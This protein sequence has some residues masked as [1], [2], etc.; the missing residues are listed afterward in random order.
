MRRSRYLAF[1]APVA[2]VAAG[3]CAP[4]L[5]LREPVP[6]TPTRFEAQIS[7]PL[8][9]AALDRWWTVFDDSQLT[10]LVEQAL[11]NGADARLAL[12]RL[13]EARAIRQAALA[14]FRVQGDLQANA[15]AQRNETLSGDATVLGSGGTGGTPSTPGGA[16]PGLPA[17]G[18]FGGDTD[19]ASVNFNLSW[20]VDLFGRRGTTR[21]G[22]EADLAAARF[23]FEGSR[24]A[25]A[26]DVADALFAARGLAVQLDDARETERIQRDLRRVLALR[27]ERGLAP[28]ADVARIDADLGQ[29]E[30]A[31]AQLEAELT[32]A[33]RA[34]LVL[35]GASTAS[36]AELAITPSLATAPQPPATLPGELLQRR[37]DVREA[38]AR[39][40]SAVAGSELRRLEL[41]PRLTLNPGVGLTA[42]GGAFDY[43]IA[44][45]TLAAGLTQP[46][47]DRPRLLAE[48]RAQN[49]RAEQA[50]VTYERTVQVAFSEAD[51][52]LVRLAA[53]QRRVASLEAGARRA[54]VSYEAARTLFTRGLNDLQALLDAER[55]YRAARQALAAARVD[56]LRRAVT[57][58]RALGGG[59]P[60]NDPET[61][62]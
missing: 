48:L 22:A 60:A 40:R 20:E 32:A 21:R 46:I 58:Y 45:W 28:D 61:V 33:K 36:T 12:A 30:A 6:A 27:A 53:D 50:A 14:R 55:S 17:A 35:T 56:A 19:T 10:G 9:A 18:L 16:N 23:L 62:G 11:A 29:A 26:A 31:R 34:I 25:L 42:S 47:L 43:T 15:S 37:P 4:T 1:A 59:W 39:F 41:F 57:S 49:A 51:Q 7:S 8:D 5:A 54:Q 44:T 3:A 13:E 52:A 2:A 24:A 38:E